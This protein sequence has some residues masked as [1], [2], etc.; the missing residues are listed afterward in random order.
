MGDSIT[1]IIYS[2][3]PLGRKVKLETLENFNLD[4]ALN[5]YRDRFADCSD[6]KFYITGDFSRQQLFDLVERY[7]AS[8][9]TSGRIEQPKDIGYRFPKD[10]KFIP[11]TTPMQ[12]PLGVVYQFRHLECP[13]TLANILTA[14]AIGSILKSKLLADLREDKGWTYSITGHGAVVCGINGDDPSEFMMPVHIKSSPEHV[15]EINATIIKTIEDMAKG[16]IS[17]N[18]ILKVKNYYLKNIVENRE[19]NSYW[20]VVM[21]ALHKYG[22]D[23]DSDYIRTVESL[24]PNSIATFIR[25]YVL[26]AHITTIQMTPSPQ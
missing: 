20:L 18:E 23:L 12:T 22:A 6:F 14:S 3:Q 8:L 9:P 11:F 17:D 13:Y 24:S 7:I 5:I 26:P 2:V 15:S 25:E 21:R 16:E 10:N 19:D 4:S 1:S